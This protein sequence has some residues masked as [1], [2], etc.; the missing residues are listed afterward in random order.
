MKEKKDFLTTWTGLILCAC[1]SCGLWGS[2][3]SVIKVSYGIYGMQPS[4]TGN[5]LLS[6]GY[7]FVI[8]GFMALLLGKLTKSGNMM[9][10]RGDWKWILPVSFFQTI[11]QYGTYYPALAHTQ[12]VTASIIIATGTFFSVVW[13]CFLFRTEKMTVGKC[14]GCFLGL[15]G[16]VLVNAIGGSFSFHLMGEG[17]ILVST[18]S[19]SI[20]SNLTAIFGK[21]I[22]PVLL[23]GWQF[24]IGGIVI[25]VLGYLFGGSFCITSM[26]GVLI[27]LYLAFVSAAAYSLWGC[28]LKKNPLSK[29]MVFNFLTPVFGV[30]FS[31][32]FLGETKKA[33]R[34]E[35]GIALVF[36]CAGI[37]LVNKGK[38]QP[39]E[40]GRG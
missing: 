8:A 30:L 2:A 15:S 38:K 13:A 3:I 4:E 10:K 17:G 33:F 27:L 6:A 14:V 31:A 28:L 7:R 26:A 34:P 1:V 16:V 11:L 25:T 36:V 37:I 12:G 39:A 20:S 18:I 24:V 32:L 22:S 35:T 19:A 40:E 29:V 5:M 23:S 21:K 9:P